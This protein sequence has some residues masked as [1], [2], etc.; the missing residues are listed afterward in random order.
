[1][2]EESANQDV[3]FSSSSRL[4]LFAIGLAIGTVIGALNYFTVGFRIFSADH[5]APQII[6]TPQAASWTI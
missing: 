2:S 1:M 5:P 6:Q 4:R 3:R